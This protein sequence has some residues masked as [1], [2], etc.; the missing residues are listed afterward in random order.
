MNPDPNESYWLI[1]YTPPNNYRGVYYWNNNEQK[2]VD[3]KNATF[4]RDR[5]IAKAYAEEFGIKLDKNT[6]IV[7]YTP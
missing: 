1:E 6:C 4:Y 2:F 3:R 5:D 7:P